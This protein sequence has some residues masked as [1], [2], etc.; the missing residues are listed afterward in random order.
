MSRPNSTVAVLVGADSSAMVNR[1]DSLANVRGITSGDSDESPHR[2]AAQSHAAYVVHDADPL[3]DVAA[4]WTG[5]FDGKG[6]PGTLEVAVEAALAAL[7][8]QDVSLPDYYI[9]LDPDSLAD[10]RKH[11]WFGVLAGVSPARVVPTAA[12]T[13]AVSGALSTLSSGRWWPDPPDEWLRGL[14]NVV[15]DR[16]GLPSS[17]AR[18]LS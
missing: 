14:R 13:T 17:R 15:P 9:V 12:T 3:A 4:A 11:W 16:A 1:L 6:E 5:F 8:R 7:R 2:R 18:S 10:T